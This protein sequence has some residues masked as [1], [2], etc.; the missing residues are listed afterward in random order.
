MVAA[1]FPVAFCGVTEILQDLGDQ[2]LFVLRI[3]YL[4]RVEMATSLNGV[5]LRT[6]YTVWV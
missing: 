1:K 6:C 4:E 3:Q 5:A 2:G